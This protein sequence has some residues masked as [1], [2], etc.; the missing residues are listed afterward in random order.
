MRITR[1]E[2]FGFKSFADRTVMHFG[3]GISCVVGPNGCG[4]SNVVDALRWCIGEQSAKSLRGGEMLD[5][6]FSGSA[7]RAP[8]GFAEVSIGLASDGG[9][10]FPG[11][12]ARLDEVSITRRLYRSGGGEYLINNVKCRRKD[13]LDLF[14]DTGVGNNLYSFIEQ[15][16]IDKIVSASSSDRRS[17]IDEAAGI[18][19]YKQR[20]K[21]AMS[22]LEATAT[23][24]DR[25]SDVTDEME[26]RL[27]QLER[28]VVRAARYRRLRALVRQQ[29]IYLG[30]ARY[31]ALMDEGNGLSAR[32]G[33]ARTEN[34]DLDESWLRLQE[35]QELR[36]GE[37][38]VAEDTFTRL[39]DE[40]AEVDAERREQEGALGFH[41]RRVDET[42]SEIDR[43]K[44]D[45]E[46]AKTTTDSAEDEVLEAEAALEELDL[47]LEEAESAASEAREEAEAAEERVQ[48]LR[49][50]Q[51]ADERELAMLEARAGALRTRTEELH[52]RLAEAPSRQD[53]LRARLGAAQ[54]EL[55]VVTKR[56]QVAAGVQEERTAL[57]EHAR[58]LESEAADQLRLAE[59]GAKDAER[60]VR[61][62]EGELDGAQK[63]L[64]RVLQQLE[65]SGSR[66][67]EALDRATR[68]AREQGARELRGIQQTGNDRAN[69]ARQ[70][71][72]RALADAERSAD[73]A[74]RD[75]ERRTAGEL[76]RLRRELEQAASDREAALERA[77]NSAERDVAA[78]AEAAEASIE[79]ENQEQMR[80]LEVAAT[81]AADR[82]AEGEVAVSDLAAELA[83]ARRHRAETQAR[84][85]AV[86]ATLDAL[87]G[88]EGGEAEMRQALGNPPS[89]GEVLD[90]SADDREWVERV[91]GE[92][93]LLPVASADQVAALEKG[94][95]Q[96]YVGEPTLQGALAGL[97]A[98]G[99]L[100]GALAS[101]AKGQ[102]AFDRSSGAWVGPGNIVEFAAAGGANVL[103]LREDLEQIDALVSEAE[104]QVE[105]L[106]QQHVGAKDALPALS[107]RLSQARQA[108][109]DHEASGRERV[110]AAGRSA[111][112]A[113]EA[114]VA[115]A[116]TTLRDARQAARDAIAADMERHRK[117]LADENA[118]AREASR[119]ELDDLREGQE[120]AEA[121]LRELLEAELEAGREHVEELV[122]AAR[123]QAHAE[124]EDR[125]N[126]LGDRRNAASQAVEAARAAVEAARLAANTAAQDR[127][128][129]QRDLDDRRTV[130]REH[131]S[132]LLRVAGELEASHASK[133]G[134]DERIR[135]LQD[136]LRRIEHE[137]A[138]A[139]EELEAGSAELEEQEERRLEMQEAA[140]EI[141]EDLESAEDR[142]RNSRSAL[143][144]AEASRAQH[145]EAR[146]ARAAALEGARSRASMGFDLLER[147]ERQLAELDIR[148]ETSKAAVIDTEAR[149]DALTNTRETLV[150]QH[151]E[152]KNRVVGLRAAVKSVEEQL[153]GIERQRDRGSR[154]LVELEAELREVQ[155]D[156]AAIVERMD[157]RY[158]VSLPKYLDHLNERGALRLT[159]DE[160]VR[161]GLEIGNK[162]VDPV[163]DLVI[164]SEMLVDK[165]AV[166]QFVQD[167]AE[168][169]KAL[170]KIGDVNL[171]ALEEY[172]EVSERYQ[173]LA[174]QREDLEESVR[175][176][177]GA[178]AKMNRTCRELFRETFDRVNEEFKKSYP[179]LV[180]GGEAFLDL[181]DE[182]DLL[183]TG[184]QIFVRPPGKR[185]S[186][187]ALLSGGEK[188]MTA[189]ALLLALFT[190]KPSP[191]CVLDEVDAPLD[192]ANGQR[193]NDMIKE[194]S[195][196]TQFIVITHNRKTMEC[197]D[198]LYGITMPTPGCSACVSVRIGDD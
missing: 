188:A 94:V 132:V 160:H 122:E 6:I 161:S 43:V 138:A 53:S 103:S 21:E 37:L 90:V 189:I 60:Q 12:Y 110:R 50:M 149:L 142:M 38:E 65:R 93:L 39:H 22:K 63:E 45:A 24:L 23:Q 186:N 158:Q 180:G 83:D 139:R 7:S 116:R 4:K 72:R 177:R 164:R 107:D 156:A 58:E 197:G 168:S 101:W 121:E 55:V 102:P 64:G 5:V 109:R 105:H 75:A 82:L 89:L 74:Q 57:V 41:R 48:E 157:E 47:L 20:R 166:T 153:A 170:Q 68:T 185:P 2:L 130:L 86:S 61:A 84:R 3:R 62:S 133:R 143:A 16:R 76:Q 104:A 49:Q 35:D 27:R 148:L 95:G 10:P 173:E 126:R 52:R 167:N 179:E 134:L 152:A 175:A 30:L 118:S 59:Q 131:D 135:E 171:Q 193:F 184:V 54:D 151:D 11:E 165:L 71:A 150:V 26:K 34:T 13:I 92:R 196:L 194:M 97:E 141:A 69:Q 51:A 117:R 56:I 111:R 28:Q 77:V 87:V 114:V 78:S 187:L 1:L 123:A 19:R 85:S 40:L 14:L 96:V 32:L 67:A 106:V 8:V 42:T 190:V 183:E 44:A 31:K 80:V 144:S 182:E 195:S 198:T 127:S 46:R 70:A 137:I 172:T 169:R 99:S 147:S 108:I 88:S 9:A 162:S 125:R 174:G 113:G 17:L 159:P 146:A 155:R 140:E 178:I 154:A 119:A 120:L 79:A 192:E 98:T 128:R 112:E 73:N 81:D 163:D 66:D 100:A 91:L 33:G 136:E 29:E 176:I 25:A 181:D 36:G 145:R 124:A 115:E 191:F 129:A 15:G 18:T